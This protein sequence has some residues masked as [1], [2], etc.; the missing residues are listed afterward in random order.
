MGPGLDI[1]GCALS[2][3]GDAVEARLVERSGTHQVRVDDP[4]HSELSSDPLRHAAAI[5]A[6]EVLRRADADRVGVALR[7][8]K[9][10]P[11]AGGQ[12]GSAASAA[13]GALATN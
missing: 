3:P 1:L 6:S 7:V 4:G 13:A 12:G 10:L 5:A 8:T 2:G 9:G 11:L